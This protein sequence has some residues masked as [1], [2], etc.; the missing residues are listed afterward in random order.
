MAKEVK[1]SL[2]VRDLLWRASIL[3]EMAMENKRLTV[4]VREAAQKAIS[5]FN[6]IQSR[7]YKKGWDWKVLSQFVKD[8]KGMI[9]ATGFKSA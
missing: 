5:N 6:R 4:T 8:A 1:V 9:E 7:G 3:G 2:G